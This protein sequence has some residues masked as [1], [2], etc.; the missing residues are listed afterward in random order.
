MNPGIDSS[1][2]TVMTLEQARDALLQLAEQTNI[3]HHR[4]GHIYNYVVGKKLA[5]T[6]GYKNAQVY[7]SQHVKVLSQAMLSMC[8]TVARAFTETACVNYGVYRLSALLTY[9][10]A[11]ALQLSREEPGPTP[12]NVPTEDGQSVEQKLFADCTLEELKLAVKSKREQDRT[13]LPDQD[14]ARVQALRE[15]IARHFTGQEPSRT[16]VKARVLKDI[17]YVTLQDVPVTHLERLTEAL[18]D[19]I[20]FSRPAT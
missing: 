4:I 10:K 13:P 16:N 6:S 8:G 5:E 19:G 9:A 17:T 14:Q 20:I 1:A 12:I 18:V 3:N 7:F 11:N 2:T 15:S